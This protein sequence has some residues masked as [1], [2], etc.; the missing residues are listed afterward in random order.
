MSEYAGEKL[1]GS[2]PEY[3]GVLSLNEELLVMTTPSIEQ[4]TFEI[5]V[6][7]HAHSQRSLFPPLPDP[8][9]EKADKRTDSQKH[10]DQRR[11]E[12]QDAAHRTS[13]QKMKE[14]MKKGKGL[15]RQ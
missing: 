8:D 15:P 9:W 2:S 4:F 5:Y 7:M 10:E 12:R 14:H 11:G 13:A 3:E 6:T 1:Q